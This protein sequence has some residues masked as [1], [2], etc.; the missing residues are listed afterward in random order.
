MG[1][2]YEEYGDETA[3]LMVFLH[4]GGVSS[5]MWS[6]QIQ[7]FTQYHCLTIDLPE[8]GKSTNSE[9]FS[10]KSSALKINNL[11]RTIAKDKEIIAIGFSLG[12]QVIIEMLSMENNVINYAVINSALTKPSPLIA[13]LI[14]PTIKLT[15][16]LLKIKTFAKLQAKELYITEDHFKTYYDESSSMKL[17]TLVR[18]LEENMLYTVRNDFENSTSKILVTV[19]EKEKSMMKKS[20]KHIV[21]LNSNCTGIVIPNVGHGAP[22]AKPTYFNVMIEKWLTTGTLPQNAKI[23]K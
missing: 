15:Y 19:G 22:L 16:P 20:A 17:D 5:W 8:Q 18:I 11:L 3:P 10:I 14:R 7:Y 21:S 4:G 9:T 23:I 6:K 2:Y 12:A 13:K 1:I